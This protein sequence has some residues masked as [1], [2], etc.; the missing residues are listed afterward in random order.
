MS[1][2]KY[3]Y[4]EQSIDTST[5]LRLY[6]C[7]SE[8][9]CPGHAWGPGIKD[10]YK[11]HYVLEGRGQFKIAGK[12]YRLGAGHGFL[13]E[14]D[15]LAW[16]Q[17]DK[18]IPW[19]YAWVAFNGTAAEGY[20]QRAGL[21]ADRP[22]FRCKVPGPME[23]SFRRLLEASRCQ[24]S[25]DLMLLSALYGLFAVLIGKNSDR[26]PGGTGP[27]RLS[28]D[29]YVQKAL[30]YIE[31]NYSHS[32]TVEGMAEQLG[33]SRKY[34]AKRFKETVGRSPQDYLV[35][36]RLGKAARLLG[37]ASLSVSEIARSVGYDD[38]LLFSRMFKKRQGMSPQQFR[39]D[40]SLPR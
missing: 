23:E 21:T 4:T 15:Q 20:L 12:E 14:P 7:G 33:L 29:R 17:A 30:E 6:Y 16:Y 8:E 38:P 2:S 24:D 1:R 19:S 25:R 9:C 40:L 39:K 32:M 28:L 35:D 13:I 36:Y 18:E 3:Q 26:P 11:I 10:H 5:D 27:A 22:V 31:T 37:D 34:M